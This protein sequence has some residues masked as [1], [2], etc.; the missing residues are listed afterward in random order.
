MTGDSYAGAPAKLSNDVG[1]QAPSINWDIDFTEKY[2]AEIWITNNRASWRFDHGIGKW[3]EFVGTHWKRDGIRGAFHS[4]GML[5]KLGNHG[6]K[7]GSKGAARS[8]FARGVEAFA[9]ADPLI[10]VEH[11]VWDCDPFA[12]GT[13]GGTVNLRTGKL[14]PA[15]PAQMISR[16]TAV[17][18]ES[19][20]PHRW[21]QFLDEATGGDA[22]LI[23]YLQQVLG[24]A[25]TGETREHALFFIYGAGK[26][27][28]SVFLN[29]AARILGDY[30]T[31]AAMDT[32]AASRGDRH[33]TELA[34]LDGARMVSASETEEGRA[35]AEARIKQLT[36]GD[37]IA[38]RFMRGDFF[39]FTPRFKLLIVGN[40][41]PSLHNVDP[42]TRR[43]F[44]IIPFTRTP[45]APDLEL[46]H[47][48]EAEH[49][50]I[51]SWMIEG[52]VDWHR[53]G[54]VRPA[55]VVMAT[56]DYFESQDVFGQWIQERCRTGPAE[57]GTPM[58]LFR[59][60]TDFARDNGEDAGVAR[61]FGSTLVKRGFR[62][63]KMAGMRCHKGLTPKSLDGARGASQDR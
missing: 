5:A 20:P 32:F 41:Q 15:L 35:W 38:A 51:L 4:I 7:G 2:A 19:G 13:P 12:L 49:G 24:Y 60:W 16:V 42:A 46:E 23:R 26:N 54:L 48:L 6:G 3:F 63:G 10:A 40:H 11:D 31:T 37:P 47:R 22:E 9:Q 29:T 33:P 14:A 58:E 21:L 30:A 50:R 18:P 44:H 39:E 43:R 61:T 55:A 53:N 28:K 56:E 36:G 52:C 34:R 27:G 17:A 57:W 59:S 25:L 1:R 45:A 8:G 62:R